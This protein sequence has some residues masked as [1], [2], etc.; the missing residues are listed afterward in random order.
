[1]N[2]LDELYNLLQTKENQKLIYSIIDEIN[3]RLASTISFKK[4]REYPIGDQYYI[5]Y[6][7]NDFDEDEGENVFYSELA[8]EI[9]D[10]VLSKDELKIVEDEHLSDEEL[11]LDYAEVG[12]DPNVIVDRAYDLS[13]N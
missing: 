1:M 2:K 13:F 6:L 10:F 7:E 11:C 9:K 5:D 8:D 4:Y 12:Y 3:D